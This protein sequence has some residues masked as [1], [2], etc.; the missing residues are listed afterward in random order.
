MD[1][2]KG[3]ASSP[4]KASH[5]KM[6]A[7]GSSIDAL[8]DSRGQSGPLPPRGPKTFIFMQISAKKLQNNRLAHPYP[9]AGSATALTHYDH[10]WRAVVHGNCYV[11]IIVYL[12]KIPVHPS[13]W[14]LPVT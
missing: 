10:T 2:G 5:K 11:T 6:A 9:V 1:G 13:P 3:H 4:V 7:E 8:V 14:K 12:H